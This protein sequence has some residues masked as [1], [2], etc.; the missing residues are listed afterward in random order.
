MEFPDGEVLV[1]NHYASGIRYDF[2]SSRQFYYGLVVVAY[3]ADELCPFSGIPEC[4]P[5]TV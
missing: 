1:T 4:I 3:I 2:R 5:H